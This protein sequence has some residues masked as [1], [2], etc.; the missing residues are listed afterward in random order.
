MAHMN[1]EMCLKTVQLAELQKEWMFY[2]S[3]YEQEV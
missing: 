1:Q 2:V 3:K